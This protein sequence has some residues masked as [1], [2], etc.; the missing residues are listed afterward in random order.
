MV[1]KIGEL[2]F[3]ALS[4]SLFRERERGRKRERGERERERRTHAY[5]KPSKNIE[6]T[7]DCYFIIK[8]II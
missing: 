1:K 3:Y 6:K 7:Y 4:L 2:L 8:T 5:A